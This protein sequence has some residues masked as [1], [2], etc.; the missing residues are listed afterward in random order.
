MAFW[1]NRRRMSPNIDGPANYNLNSIEYPKKF[2]LLGPYQR[3]WPVLSLLQGQLHYW[4]NYLLR[5]LKSFY[6]LPNFKIFEAFSSFGVE[7][8][9]SQFEF[10]GKQNHIAR[11]FLAPFRILFD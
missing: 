8:T 4:N 1:A 5:L 11:V 3:V 7:R 9:L 2:N 6:Y 10:S